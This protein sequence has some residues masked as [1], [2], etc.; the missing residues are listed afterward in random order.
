MSDD[1]VRLL[2]ERGPATDLE[3]DV[4]RSGGDVEPPASAHDAVWASLQARLPAGDGNG[5]G[6]A[7]GDGGLDGAGAGA[8]S[9]F[10]GLVKG[11]VALVVAGVLVGIAVHQL[12]SPPE[13]PAVIAASPGSAAL[14]APALVDTAS[15][16]AAN[17]RAPAVD[18]VAPQAS[19]SAATSDR[20]APA[21]KRPSVQSPRALSSV[22]EPA[23]TTKVPSAPSASATGPATAPPATLDALREESSLLAAARAAVRRGDSRAALTS[24]EVARSRYPNGALL[25][26]REVLTIEALAQNGQSEEAS[27]RAAAF[28]RAF[29]STP[30]AA[31]VR[32]F[33]R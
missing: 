11:A 9:P 16:T 23:Q 21:S 28:L 27:R 18:G 26:E 8:T 4:L 13:G 2:D 19:T 22:S 10:A 25:Q 30:H 15:A 32:A 29:P 7:G 31:R 33:V 17:D 24:L 5:G 14:V 1:P 6:S 20:P 3:R 12:R